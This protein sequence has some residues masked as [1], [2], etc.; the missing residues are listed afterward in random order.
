LWLTTQREPTPD[1]IARGA[2]LLEKLKAKHELA[3]AD[4]MKYLCLVLLNA[5]EFVYVD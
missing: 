1:D 5:S 4:A 3:D 2:A